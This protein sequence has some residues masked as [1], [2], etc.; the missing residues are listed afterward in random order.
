V[1][2][3]AA[4]RSSLPVQAVAAAA[5][6]PVCTVTLTPMGRKMARARARRW[7]R[8]KRRA[9]G[10]RRKRRR[11]RTKRRSGRSAADASDA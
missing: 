4:P 8:R 5:V 3:A 11:P 6:V 2:A 7:V 9:A 1:V 10:I